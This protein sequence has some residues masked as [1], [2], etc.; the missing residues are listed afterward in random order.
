[1]H[2]PIVLKHNEKPLFN[3]A[4]HN[5]FFILDGPMR[6]PTPLSNVES[7]TAL[8]NVEKYGFLIFRC[9]KRL[10]NYVEKR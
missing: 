10:F 6:F 5:V 3:I 8:N 2:L 4:E 1:M 7:S 9:A